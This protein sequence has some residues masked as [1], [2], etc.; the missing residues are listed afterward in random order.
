MPPS[1]LAARRSAADYAPLKSPVNLAEFTRLQN[2]G[3]WAVS[4]DPS[5]KSPSIAGV[6]YQ[7]KCRNLYL[8]H[9]ARR[10]DRRAGHVVFG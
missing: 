8:R 2:Q 1:G 9:S 4:R 5:G 6:M 10:R 3:S 7:I